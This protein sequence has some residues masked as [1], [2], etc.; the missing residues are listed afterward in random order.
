MDTVVIAQVGE[1]ASYTILDQSSWSGVI[2]D[3]HLYGSARKLTKFNAS[4]QFPSFNQRLCSAF[5]AY[6]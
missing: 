2:L 1:E 5:R 4:S 3:L 6:D